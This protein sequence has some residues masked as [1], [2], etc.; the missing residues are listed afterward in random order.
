MREPAARGLQGE[1]YRTAVGRNRERVTDVGVIR[2]RRGPLDDQPVV[3]TDQ[4][5]IAG[6]RAEK[7]ALRRA[8][9]P[10]DAVD[11]R[12]NVGGPA[13]ATITPAPERETLALLPGARRI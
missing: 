6:D 11:R 2:D 10:H 3:G 13:L 4:P 9:E 7:Y 1:L 5:E 12:R 8:H